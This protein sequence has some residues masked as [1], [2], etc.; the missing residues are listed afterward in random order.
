MADRW[1]PHLK[2]YEPVPDPPAPRAP[3]AARDHTDR[4]PRNEAV[5]QAQA[6]R[7]AELAGAY[8]AVPARTDGTWA[9]YLSSAGTHPD[10]QRPRTTGKQ[11]GNNG[12]SSSYQPKGWDSVAS[13]FRPG[14]DDDAP[15]TFS[16]DLDDDNVEVIDGHAQHADVQEQPRGDQSRPGDIGIREFSKIIGRSPRQIKRWE[17]SAPGEEPVLSPARRNAAGARCYTR[18]Y[19]GAVA[20][21]VDAE[22]HERGTDPFATGFP[23]RARAAYQRHEADISAP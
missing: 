1:N 5:A 22:L 20:A 6:I 3:G 8:D 7:Q 4:F 19:A 15:G 18:G 11:S 10:Q 17:S 12:R 21:L 14:H 13:A 23:D 2:S 16:L 9:E